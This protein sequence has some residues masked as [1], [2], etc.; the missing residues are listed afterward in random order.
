MRGA[1]V[2]VLQVAEPLKALD[3]DVRRFIDERL[4]RNADS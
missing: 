3:V 1:Y 4:E 2:E